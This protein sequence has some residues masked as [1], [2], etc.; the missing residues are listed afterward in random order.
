MLT[1]AARL[2]GLM[3]YAAIGLVLP[4]GFIIAPLLWLSRR[5]G[6]GRLGER[7]TGAWAIRKLEDNERSRGPTFP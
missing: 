5:H 7:L 2:K 4:G 1:V 3:P 6:L